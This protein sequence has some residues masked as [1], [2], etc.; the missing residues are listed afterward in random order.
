M[1]IESSVGLAQESCSIIGIPNM[2]EGGDAEILMGVAEVWFMIN[3]H[4][5]YVNVER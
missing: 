5:Y 2:E 3:Y 4:N 1:I